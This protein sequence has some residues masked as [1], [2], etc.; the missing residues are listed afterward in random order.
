[1]I[2]ILVPLVIAGMCILAINLF[3]MG[4]PDGGHN[5]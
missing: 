3:V 4:G 5:E 2:T 1:M